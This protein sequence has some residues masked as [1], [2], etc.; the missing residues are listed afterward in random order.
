M[1][2]AP[3]PARERILPVSPGLSIATPHGAVFL[4]R[5]AEIVTEVRTLRETLRREKDWR[6]K[7]VIRVKSVFGL[8]GP[9]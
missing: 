2:S 8:P 5:F 4:R 3:S 7:P 1:A 6:V 9:S